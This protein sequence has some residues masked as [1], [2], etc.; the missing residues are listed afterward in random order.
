[1]L[2]YRALLVDT[3]RSYRRPVQQFF[4]CMEQAKDWATKTLAGASDTAYVTFYKLQE[5]EVF[6]MRKPR[7]QEPVQ[8][9]QQAGEKASQPK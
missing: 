7:D 2:M 5:T 8:S 4:S 3:E 1:M 6:E 9:V